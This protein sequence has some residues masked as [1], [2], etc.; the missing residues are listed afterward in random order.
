LAETIYGQQLQ[1]GMSLTLQQHCEVRLNMA[2]RRYLAAIRT[3]ATVRRLLGPAA[4]L[5]HV[6]QAGQVNIGEKQTNGTG[7]VPSVD[8]YPG[9]QGGA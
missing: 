4:P 6:E 9:L 7:P 2:Q 3:L 1:Q 8:G 5:V